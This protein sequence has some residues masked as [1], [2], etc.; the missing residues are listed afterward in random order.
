MQEDTTTPDFQAGAPKLPPSHE[1]TL[2]T[3]TAAR[4]DLRMFSRKQKVFYG[5]SLLYGEWTRGTEHEQYLPDGTGRFWDTGDDVGC[6]EALQFRWT[7]DSNV[8]QMVFKLTMGGVV[9]KEYLVTFADDESLVYRDDVGDS[10]MWDK[11]ADG[12]GDRPTAVPLVS[13]GNAKP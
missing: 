7:L 10:Y 9:P 13:S 2:Q 5:A 1:F 6:G 11:A 4:T 8:L 12:S 3:D